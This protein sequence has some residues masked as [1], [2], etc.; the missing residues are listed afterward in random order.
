MVVKK[1][2]A[3]V[4]KRIYSEFL[5]GRGTTVIANGLKADGIKTARNKDHWYDHTVL[6]ILK[7]EKY[8]G[9]IMWNKQITVDFMNKKRIEN[10][11]KIP[12]Y[13]VKD[14]HEPIIEKDVWDAVQA[15]LHRR[16][17]SMTPPGSKVK[18]RFSSF[19]PMS[20]RLF[21]GYCGEPLTRKQNTS[22][23]DGVRSYYPMWRCRAA[24]GKTDLLADCSARSYRESSLSQ[25][26][27]VLLM[28]MKHEKADLEVEAR[29]AIKA[30]AL[31]DWELE[32]LKVIEQDISRLEIK[33]SEAA[34]N[35]RPGRNISDIYDELS[36]RLSYELE[37]LKREGSR[38]NAQ[39]KEYKD[40]KETLEWFLSELDSIADFDPE[41][42]RAE[43]REDIFH[44]IVERGIVY[45]DGRIVYEF[46]F[47]IKREALGNDCK[48]YRIDRPKKRKQ[49]RSRKK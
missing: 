7:N 46:S 25:S 29:A 15:E 5:S 33:L 6:R 22:T 39:Q 47:G 1:E 16:A 23:Y 21:C 18:V 42:E 19:F 4:V 32:R 37:D 17:R 43:F 10:D 41:T 13:Y 9:A 27:Q 20:N 35:A 30:L 11:H 40:I 28:H 24:D 34:A 45:D 26:F 8:Y 14:H 36:I 38:L 31:E 12:K 3:K 49:T 44:R 48:A 2:E